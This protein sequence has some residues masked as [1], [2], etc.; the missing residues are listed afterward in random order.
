MSGVACGSA[1]VKEAV[2]ALPA[3]QRWWVRITGDTEM[4]RC[5][6]CQ[7]IKQVIGRAGNRNQ[8]S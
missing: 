1:A 7:V 5:D 2:Q 6:L 8:F 3:E 4:P